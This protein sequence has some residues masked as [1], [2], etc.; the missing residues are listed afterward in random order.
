MRN[1]E[2]RMAG[3]YEIIQSVY[4][5]DKE[6]VLGEN[7]ADTSG[8]KYLCS[9]CQHSDWGGYHQEIF[10]SNSY[11]ETMRIFGER[12][13]KQTEKVQQELDRKSVV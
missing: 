2:K 1:S 7:L 12:I 11:L 13:V 6:V 8:G 10:T 9:L 4:V 5:G 3:D